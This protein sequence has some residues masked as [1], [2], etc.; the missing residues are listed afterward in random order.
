MIKQKTSIAKRVFITLL[1]L[2][3]IIS[4]EDDTTSNSFV[5]S[6]KEKT[7][8]LSDKSSNLKE[9]FLVLGDSVVIPS[10]EIKI[11]LTENAKKIIKDKNESIVVQAYFSGEFIDKGNSKKDEEGANLGSHRISLYDNYVAEFENVKIAKE[12]FEQLSRKNFEVL[13]NVFSGRKSSPKNLIDCD[14]LQK[15]I[16][17]LKDKQHVLHG[18]LIPESIQ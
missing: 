15:N 8:T 5:E 14:I 10:F 13:I 7:D 18:K 17:D 16:L 11:K 3:L 4:C 1:T 9:D 2:S 12:K 6:D